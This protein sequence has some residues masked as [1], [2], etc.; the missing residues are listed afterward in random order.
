MKKKIE[1]FTLAELLVVV[2]IIGI[3]V[4]VSIPIF[5]S[6]GEKTKAAA[7]M[8]N[9]RAAKAAAVAAYLTDGLSGEQVYYYDAA[10]GTVT[11]DSKEAAK[12]T[13][14]GKSTEAIKTK[15]N[16]NNYMGD[17]V[18]ND[19]T[20]ANIVK[21]TIAADGTQSAEWGSGAGSGGSGGSESPLSSITNTTKW[22]D[23]QSAINS[24][25]GT[26]LLPGT[27]VSDNGK[28]YLVYG[29]KNWYQSSTA[30][31]MAD[32]VSSFSTNVEEVTSSTPLITVTSDMANMKITA[33]TIALYKGKYYCAKEDISYNEWENKTP[34]TESRFALIKGQ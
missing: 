9:V 17:G 8:A 3:L 34:D 1:G 16:T 14:Y 23:I 25:N 26:T 5:A 15:Y 22:S 32:L 6:Q 12:I 27:L 29:N 33:G 21:I 18:P 28:Q 4:A 7:D 19:G 10:N 31:S 24:Q 13:G 30:K 11:T 2:A 20:K